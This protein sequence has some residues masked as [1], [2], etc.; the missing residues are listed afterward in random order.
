LRITNGQD[1]N[2]KVKIVGYL[3]TDEEDGCMGKKE[4][5]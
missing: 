4:G 2:R 5:F 3:E 1:L